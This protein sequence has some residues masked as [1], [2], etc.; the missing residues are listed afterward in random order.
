MARVDPQAPLI[1]GGDPK[2]LAKQDQHT[3]PDEFVNTGKRVQVNSSNVRA[4]QYDRGKRELYVY[5]RG[6]RLKPGSMYIYTNVDP[7]V[8]REMLTASSMG[9]FVHQRLRGKYIFHGP[10]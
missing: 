9:K 2:R 5:F 1:T 7:H 10:L 3:T 4:I 6:T 8:A